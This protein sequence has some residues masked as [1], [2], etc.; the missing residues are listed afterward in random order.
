[1]YKIKYTAFGKTRM[2]DVPYLHNMTENDV[3]E[4]TLW[5]ERGEDYYGLLSPQ[6]RDKRVAVV[7]RE[8][9][10]RGTNVQN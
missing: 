1:M 9:W 10:L 6:L 4:E 8:N 5:A 3:H 2:V 7:E